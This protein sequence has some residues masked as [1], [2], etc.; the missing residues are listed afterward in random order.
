[1]TSLGAANAER[2][3]EAVEDYLTAI[4]RLGG[5]GAVTT[6]TLARSLEVS[7]PSATEMLKRL[8]HQRLV[9]YQ[10]YQ[11]VAL[12]A[13]GRRIAVRV[14]R[15]HRLIELFLAKVL[16]LPVERVHAE[17][18]R[19]EHVISEEALERI[20]LSLGDPR[21]DVHGHPIPAADGS[22]AETDDLPLSALPAG[23]TAEVSQLSDHDPELLRHLDALGLRPGARIEAIGVDP[24]ARS[25]EVRVGRRRRRLPE[26]AAG[27][28]RVRRLEREVRP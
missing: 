23:A 25:L 15:A 20:A 2:R 26:H 6:S 10:P 9:R 19:W 5:D 17:A 16:H 24:F 22:V 3:S 14:I 7:A 21:T 4:W 12:T 13:S 1:M 18:H 28:V 27:S 11:G 8:S